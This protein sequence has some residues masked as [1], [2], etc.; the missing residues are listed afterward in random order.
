M[1][2]QYF[3]LSS[4]QTDCLTANTTVLQW[5]LSNSTEYIEP[6]ENTTLVCC[7]GQRFKNHKTA[8]PYWSVRDLRSNH[9][10]RNSSSSQ[11]FLHSDHDLKT[12][13][14]CYELLIKSVIDMTVQCNILVRNTVYCTFPVYLKIDTSS[15]YLTV[16]VTNSTDSPVTN[17][18][19]QSDS[20]SVIF[21]AVPISLGVIVIVIIIGT[22]VLVTVRCKTLQKCKGVK[23]YLQLPP[24]PKKRLICRLSNNT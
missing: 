6:W 10:I 8:I 1:Q 11:W 19:H 2:V 14:A 21:Y 7:K 20:L 13:D 17:G 9:I 4:S 3:W 23:D 5:N 22:L 16:H 15:T 24:P 12:N 18:K